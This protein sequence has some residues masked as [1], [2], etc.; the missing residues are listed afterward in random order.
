MKALVTGGT[1]F[2]GG[3]VVRELLRRGHEVKVLARATSKTGPLERLGVKIAWGTSWT[4]RR[5]PAP[6]KD[7]TPCFTPPR[8]TS[9]G[10]RIESS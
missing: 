2:V 7:A 8:S 6:W 3:A 9:S 1:G 5:S 4:A 10:Y